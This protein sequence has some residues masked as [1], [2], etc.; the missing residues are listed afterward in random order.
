MRALLLASLLFVLAVIVNSA[1]VYLHKRYRIYARFGK[2]ANTSHSFVILPLWVLFALTASKMNGAHQ[3]KVRWGFEW[4]G[5]VLIIT[6]ISLFV[7]A[8]R[9]IGNQALVNGDVFKPTKR[10]DAG[11][12]KLLKNPIYDSYTILLLGLGFAYQNYGYV[13]LAVLSVPLLHVIEVR[14]E[15]YKQQ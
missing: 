11:V 3:L 15:N 8:I 9:A 14:A 1:S 12:Y 6:A 13:I 4:V 7:I 5:G 10:T 2:H